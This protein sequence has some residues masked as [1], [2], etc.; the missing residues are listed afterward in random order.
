MVAGVGG[1]V[2]A[3][4]TVMLSSAADPDGVSIVLASA[5]GIAVALV[6][7]WF[8]RGRRGYPLRWYLTVALSV[9]GSITGLVVLMVGWEPGSPEAMG[10]ALGA[11]ISYGLLLGTAASFLLYGLRGSTTRHRGGE[12]RPQ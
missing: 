7:Y 10:F 4:A 11:G 3:L 2:L 1:G 9:A 12:A 6:L 5:T 8:G